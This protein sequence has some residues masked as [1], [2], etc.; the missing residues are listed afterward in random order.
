ML[1]HQTEQDRR[2]RE[3]LDWLK[4]RDESLRAFAARSGIPA[5]T[6][7]R[8]TTGKTTKRFDLS[9]TKKIADATEG[10]IGHVEVSAYLARLAVLDA[11]SHAQAA[12]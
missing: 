11:A 7:S 10:A 9:I 12:E 4:A 3:L 8:F 2:F 5:A 6:L 1:L